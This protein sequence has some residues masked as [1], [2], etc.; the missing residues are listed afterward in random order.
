MKDKV[1]RSA[2]QLGLEV[3]VRELETSTRTVA[4]AARALGC[5]EA[6]IAKSIVFVCD[7]E[8]IVCV[9][10]GEHRIDPD[11]LAVVHDCAEVRQAGADEVRAATGFPVG[12]VPPIGHDLPVIVDEA[13]LRHRRIWAAAGTGDSLFCL[14]PRELVDCLQADVAELAESG[15]VAQPRPTG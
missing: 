1:V 12:A 8:P 11:K 3:E 5:G 10:S 9:A 2:R 7:G 4:D 6:E 15:P 14:D 13:L